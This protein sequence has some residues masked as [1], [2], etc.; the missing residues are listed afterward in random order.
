[1]RCLL[2]RHAH[3]LERLFVWGDRDA[4]FEDMDFGAE[5]QAAELFNGSTT[6]QIAALSEAEAIAGL[7]A[8]KMKY[9]LHGL[10]LLFM[11]KHLTRF[12]AGG[13]GRFDVSKDHVDGD[14]LL[15]GFDSMKSTTCMVEWNNTAKTVF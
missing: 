14:N 11:H 7:Y 1:L 8:C 9:H 12:P 6:G 3:N 5:A 4:K 15:P 13:S 10:R 2:S